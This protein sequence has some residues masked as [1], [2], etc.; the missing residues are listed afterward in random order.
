M[1]N[2]PDKV[3]TLF[4]TE[5]HG[6]H[7]IALLEDARDADDRIYEVRDRHE[8]GIAVRFL[9]SELASLSE[10]WLTEKRRLCISDDPD[11]EVAEY[12]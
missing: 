8:D 6:E 3:N 11:T 1:E 2:M 10:W 4:I 5:P 12:E 7:E 9:G